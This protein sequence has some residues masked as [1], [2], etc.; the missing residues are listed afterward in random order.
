MRYGVTCCKFILLPYL[1]DDNSL[2]FVHNRYH[3]K[4][5]HDTATVHYIR[6]SQMFHFSLVTAPA[7]FLVSKSDPVGAEASN[8][9]VRDCLESKNI[10][11]SSFLLWYSDLNNWTPDTFLTQTTWKCW[12]RSP[13]VGHFMKHRDEYIEAV[14]SHLNSVNLL[15]HPEK[16]RAKLWAD[17]GWF[18]KLFHLIKINLW[19]EKWFRITMKKPLFGT[20]SK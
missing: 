5:F 9:R 4:T 20:F 11:V 2:H 12:D 17:E 10:H 15:R 14:F 19:L 3:L 18:K 1:N 6:S 16:I 13:H 7:L 8:M